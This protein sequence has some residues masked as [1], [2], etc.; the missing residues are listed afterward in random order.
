M[1]VYPNS[2]K[3]YSGDTIACSAD[4]NPLPTYQWTLL[5]NGTV[6]NGSILSVTDNMVGY[7]F[8]FRCTATNYFNSQSF[9]N[10]ADIAF[11]VEAGK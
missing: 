11:Y 8:A 5:P 7:N 2:T 9:T 1:S 10:F 4:G 6:T 3:Y